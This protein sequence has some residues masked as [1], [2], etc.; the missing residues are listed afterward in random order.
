MR[1]VREDVRDD[2]RE[3]V[4]IDVRDALVTQASGERL[5][6]LHSLQEGGADFS[7]DQRDWIA[8]NVLGLAQGHVTVLHARETLVRVP[9]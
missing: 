2:V 6:Q 1:D 7:Y 5:L 9:C 4:S 3:L 8:R